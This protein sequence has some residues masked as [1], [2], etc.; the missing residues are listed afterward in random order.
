MTTPASHIVRLD[1]C[2]SPRFFL[3][4]TLALGEITAKDIIKD[5]GS[6]ITQYKDAL[7]SFSHAYRNSAITNTQ[8]VVH[9]LKNFMEQIGE[10]STNLLMSGYC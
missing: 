10:F 5:F 8:V 2:C 9:Q 7:D 1:L 3:D 6:A 4:V